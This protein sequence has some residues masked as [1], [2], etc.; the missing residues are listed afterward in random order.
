M[1]GTSQH[2]EPAP[3]HLFCA[4]FSLLGNYAL[5]HFEPRWESLAWISPTHRNG[6]LPIIDV[7]AREPKRSRWGEETEA[8]RKGS[9]SP[10]MMPV[11]TRQFVSEQEPALELDEEDLDLVEPAVGRPLRELLTPPEWETG[12]GEEEPAPIIPATFAEEPFDPEPSAAVVGH[13]AGGAGQSV[14]LRHVRN[15]SLLTQEVT[16]SGTFAFRDLHPGEYS[17]TV[18]Q[19]NLRIDHVKVGSGEEQNLE[20]TMPEWSW[21]V[22]QSA[23]DK[24]F[25]IVRCSVEG[26]KNLPVRIW[27]PTW[28]GIEQRTGAKPEYGPFYCELAPL[29][30]G[31]YYL[32]VEGITQYVELELGNSTITHVEFVRTSRQEAAPETPALPTDKGLHRYLLLARPFGNKEDLLAM[33]R[34]VR[35]HRP[36]CG[37]SIEEALWADEVIIV[38][39]DGVRVTERDRRLLDESGCRVQRIDGDIAHTLNQ[40]ADMGEPFIEQPHES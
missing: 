36:T 17:L 23:G 11:G 37:F 20:L 28:D 8:A 25:A 40:L 9:I 4:T 30:P 12:S 2:F 6:R 38:G 21:Q 32:Q 13:L 29:G 27:N 26:S 33:L 14:T 34:F 39:A 10:F 31:R 35:V 3:G 22:V 15:A 16:G 24:G 18:E 1:M 7:L 5:A 19:T